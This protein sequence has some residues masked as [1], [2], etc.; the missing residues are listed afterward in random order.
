MLRENQKDKAVSLTDKFFEAFPDMN[1]AYDYRTW[2]MIGVYLQADAYEKAKPKIEILARNTADNLEYY[3][4]L[5]D[6]I[7]ESSYRAE[8]VLSYNTMESILKEV[9]RQ[10][11]DEFLKHLQEMFAPYMVEEGAKD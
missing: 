4:S 3:L 1:F 5:D 7:I 8:T 2:P 11:D 9:E 6:S 10:K